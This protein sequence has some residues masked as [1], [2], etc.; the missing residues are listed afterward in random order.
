MAG[1]T[2]PLNESEHKMT[3]IPTDILITLFT[4]LHT[5][6]PRL[7]DLLLSCRGV[8]REWRDVVEWVLARPARGIKR[9]LGDA[10]GSNPAVFDLG[11]D[12]H[13]TEETSFGWVGECLLP[14]CRLC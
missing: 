10:G 1:Q 11:M 2:G 14:F 12:L 5:S 13:P 7:D 4:R 6:P 3:H 9:G 8:C